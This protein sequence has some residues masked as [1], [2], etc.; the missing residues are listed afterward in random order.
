MW[1]STSTMSYQKP[2]TAEW[3]KAFP[4]DFIDSALNN[5]GNCWII[6]KKNSHTMG[7]VYYKNSE[8]TINSC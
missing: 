7:K 8:Y 3:N 6:I 2:G 5:A 1:N 4:F